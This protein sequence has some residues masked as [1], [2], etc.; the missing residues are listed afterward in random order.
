MGDLVGSIIS[1]LGVHLLQLENILI[2]CLLF[3][4]Q[5]VFVNFSVA[6]FNPH[7]NTL[8]NR[9]VV[10]TFFWVLGGVIL[11]LGVTEGRCII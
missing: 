9:V 4:E 3:F 7:E 5:W 11:G 8:L 10:R 1:K 6:L 2:L